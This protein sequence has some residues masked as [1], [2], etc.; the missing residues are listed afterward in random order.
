MF[1]LRHCPKE[2]IFFSGGAPL[3]QMIIVVIAG[4][5]SS[6][7]NDA[8]F[9]DKWSCTSFLCDLILFAGKLWTSL[10]KYRSS[11]E[12]CA[13]L[14]PF[15]LY[16]VYLHCI[17]ICT[18]ILCSSWV[19][20]WSSLAPVS[21]FFSFLL[22]QIFRN[23]RRQSL[24][25][26]QKSWRALRAQLRRFCWCRLLSW[27]WQW[28]LLWSSKAPLKRF[29]C[30]SS[31]KCSPNSR[32]SQLHPIQDDL[33]VNFEAKKQDVPKIRNPNLDYPSF[34]DAIIVTS[35]LEKGETKTRYK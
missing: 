29:C 5:C 22:T 19:E 24:R 11:V 16:K 7:T 4:F 30:L 31:S 8:A 20:R 25:N 12:R 2:N 6:F 34:S 10:V 14:E 32:W 13:F 15:T 35:S 33:D 23:A 3:V 21:K 28:G 18:C 1:S 9:S 17:C 27:C 26:W